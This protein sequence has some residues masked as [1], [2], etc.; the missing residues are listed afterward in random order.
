MFVSQ[1][2]QSW[3]INEDNQKVSI[4]SKHHLVFQINN[5]LIFS[6]LFKSST[7]CEFEIKYWYDLR[8]IKLV[9]YIY[10]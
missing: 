6:I 1:F 3:K 7:K 4:V 2:I 10:I 9:R 5:I 8:T